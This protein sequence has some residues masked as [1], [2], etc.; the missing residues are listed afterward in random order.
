MA[1]LK[2]VD[3]DLGVPR[4]LQA[5]YAA[6]IL[7]PETLF[8]FEGTGESD[9]EGLIAL[10]RRELA[11]SLVRHIAQTFWSM[12]PR[13]VEQVFEMFTLPTFANN[14]NRTDTTGLGPTDEK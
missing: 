7:Q 10:S 2:K 11:T 5:V 12:G 3:A 13:G 6:I 4:G 9:E 8:R 14:F 1:L